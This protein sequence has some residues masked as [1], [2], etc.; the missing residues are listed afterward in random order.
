MTALTLAVLLALQE[1]ERL[2]ATIP[3]GVEAGTVGF[4]ADGKIAAYTAKQG[5]QFWVVAS[6]WKSKPRPFPVIFSV[7]PSGKDILYAELGRGFATIHLT[8]TVLFEIP[9]PNGWW[10]PGVA[11]PDGKTVLNYMRDSK[12]EKCAVAVNGKL[13]ALHKGNLAAPVVSND[14]KRFAFALETDDGH[15]IVVNDKPG[16]TYDWVTQPV[17]SADGTVLAYGAESEN[18]FFI[19]HGEKKVPVERP[20]KGVFLTSDGASV[21]WWGRAK[22]E[23]PKS[24]ERVVAGGKEGPVFASL[25]PPVFSPD[26]KH[27]AYRATKADKTWCV[28]VDDR[29][30]DVGDIQVDPVFMPGAKQVGFGFRKGRELWWKTLDVK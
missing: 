21:G 7:L 10:F 15:C 9:N 30:V 1:G 26:G 11:T 27:V 14:G 16:P 28:I 8:D 6:E 29:V 3:E 13:Q 20:I 25:R 22:K 24:G 19:V 12:T 4:S 23:D 2:V 17:L 18:K 5:E